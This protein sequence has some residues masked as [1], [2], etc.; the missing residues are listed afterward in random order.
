MILR[1]K[2][3]NKFLEEA[4]DKNYISERTPTAINW[5]RRKIT[6]LFSDESVRI[7]RQNTDEYGPGSIYLFQYDPKYKDNKKI[8]P[9]YDKFPLCL[10][11][12]IYE[13]SFLG[14]NLHYLR[15]TQ[16]A[17]FIAALYDYEVQIKTNKNKKTIINISYEDLIKRS[18][19]KY[20]KPCIK[21]YLA[22]NVVVSP[23]YK[24]SPEEWNYVLF[25]PTEK[26]VGA[27]S[28]QVWSESSKRIK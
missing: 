25:L 4:Q 22:E 3:F 20:Y 15:P 19:L 28:S 27:S 13:D 18:A 16:R 7:K 8:L 9:Y 23:F 6:D 26:F 5:M 24:V 11:L 1:S 17:Q 10:I 12:D 21:R 2:S 14:L